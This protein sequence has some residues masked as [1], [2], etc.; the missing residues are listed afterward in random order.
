MAQ[1]SKQWFEM[2]DLHVKD[3]LP[4]MITLSE[5]YIQVNKLIF[6]CWCFLLYL[7]E[8]HDLFL[9]K[10]FFSPDF[11]VS[12]SFSCAINAISENIVLP[13]QWNMY[14]KFLQDSSYLFQQLDL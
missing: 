14:N 3:I 11:I 9:E 10:S 4:P 8:S 1:G 13:L 5:S 2:Q 12:W 7:A 6:T